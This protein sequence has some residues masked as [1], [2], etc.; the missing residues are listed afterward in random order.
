MMAARDSG[1]PQK[2]FPPER[3]LDRD[4]HF[5]AEIGE[6][7]AEFDAILPDGFNL[8]LVNFQFLQIDPT[9][10]HSQTCGDLAWFFNENRFKWVP[11]FKK[12]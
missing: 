8:I 11:R 5:T 12:K 9:N 7:E 6:E 4:R 3:Q 2:S 10:F 1:R